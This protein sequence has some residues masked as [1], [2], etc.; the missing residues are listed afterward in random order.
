MQLLLDLKYF[1]IMHLSLCR[2][3][4]G[5]SMP[6]QAAQSNLTKQLPHGAFTLNQPGSHSKV[7]RNFTCSSPQD[8][9]HL[10]PGMLLRL[11]TAAAAM[12]MLLQHRQ[13]P[14]EKALESK[15]RL[16][17]QVSSSQ[18]A[19]Q[20]IHLQPTLHKSLLV[21]QSTDSKRCLQGSGHQN[22]CSRAD[23][24]QIHLCERHCLDQDLLLMFSSM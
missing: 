16:C 22:C 14:V 24:W 4:T 18:T 7:W 20:E 1:C 2:S 21:K 23:V 10:V 8:A 13:R 19:F 12:A 9:T 11:S 5:L 3:F 17:K 6:L 15:S